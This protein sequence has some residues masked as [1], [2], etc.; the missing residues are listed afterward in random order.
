MSNVK[1]EELSKHHDRKGFYCEVEA[2]NHYLKTMALQHHSRD[3]AKTHVLTFEDDSGPVIAYAT[4]NVCELD[5]SAEK[6]T[7]LLKKLPIN[8]PAVRLCRLAVD[9]EHQGKGLG[10]YMLGFTLSKA[11]EVSQN[12]GCSGIVVDAK[13][14]SAQTFYEQF[15]FI[16]F[17]SN[18]L[19][20]F[21]PMRTITALVE[22]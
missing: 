7:P 1:I 19:R 6:Q 5:L 8:A 14:E 20:L 11:L 9:K 13:D 16:S 15:G 17:T 4:L 12:V 22:K 2:L 10:Q 3:I 18:P 21:L